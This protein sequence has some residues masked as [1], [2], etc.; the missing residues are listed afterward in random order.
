VERRELPP[1]ERAEAV[2]RTPLRLASESGDQLW[3]ADVEMLRRPRGRAWQ[4]AAVCSDRRARPDAPC[5]AQR[6]WN[7]LTTLIELMDSAEES[8]RTPGR[9]GGVTLIARVGW[10]PWNSRYLELR[11]QDLGD[12]LRQLADPR[13]AGGE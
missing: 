10:K 5:C 2:R 4:L 9:R 8:F 11:P 12:H 6:R 1:V 3:S 13:I 7:L